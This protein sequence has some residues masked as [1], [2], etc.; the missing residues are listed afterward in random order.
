MAGG[1]LSGGQR[2]RV[3]IARALVRQP[4]ILIFDEATSALDNHTQAIVT[5]SLASLDVTRI[6]IAHRLSTIRNADRIVVID[7]GQ[8]R[9]RQLR[10]PYESAGTVFSHDGASTVMSL[11]RQN[12]LDALSNP[13]K[14]DQPLRLLRP[15]QWL[16]LFSLGGFCLSI[17][18]WSVLGRLPVRISG[19]GVLIRQDSL[20]VVQ[21]ESS[22][23]L[24]DLAV[25]VGDCVEAGQVLA[26]VEPLQEQLE[27]E[28]ARI[29]LAQLQQHDAD[30]DQ[31]AA[32]R[33]EQLRRSID[34]VD[35]LAAIGA[36]PVDELE[37]RQQQMW[38]LE[39]SI[40]SRNSQREQSI[41]QQ[42]SRISALTTKMQ[43]TA[44]I[45]APV[46][47]C[48]VDSSIHLDEVVQP[49]AIL[50]TLDAGAAESGLE[51]YA[52]FPA[53]D[54]KRGSLWANRCGYPRQA[55]NPSV[56]VALK[57]SSPQ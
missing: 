44:S 11:F 46:A 28:Q 19:R 22:G 35:D 20:K 5:K 36:F 8:V 48:I 25:E 13:E 29:Q 24:Q 38:D 23:R 49:G 50:F 16:L 27:A 17:L 7:R 45:S 37:R 14:L 57:E 34:R 32:A 6:V 18:T 41:T 52:Y 40:A 51:S 26:R 1:L 2:Q 33:M 53:R 47:G 55:P 9:K 10:H 42:T 21:S 4:Q 3:A 12:A 54:G 15:R 30:L 39:D 56:T 43:H 31:L